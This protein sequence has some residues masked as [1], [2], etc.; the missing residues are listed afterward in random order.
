MKSSVILPNK[1]FLDAESI[2][3][4]V[5][6]AVY[7]TAEA[8]LIDFQVTTRTWVHK[9]LFELSNKDTERIVC[10]YSK[11]YRFVAM[12]TSVRRVAMSK[13]FRAKTVVNAIRSNV[14]KGGVVFFSKKLNLPGIKARNFH[15][16]I[17]KKWQPRLV[18]LIQ[19]SIKLEALRQGKLPPQIHPL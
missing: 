14:G 12:G 7:S 6:V 9:P 10:T 15:K 4:A 1:D 13:N 18:K 16:V 8:A 3:N 5:R 17:A 19:K 2:V 11:I